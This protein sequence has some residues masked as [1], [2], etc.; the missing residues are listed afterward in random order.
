MGRL[1]MWTLQY[2]LCRQIVRSLGWHW[3]HILAVV[4]ILSC[5]MESWIAALYLGL[6]CAAATDSHPNM[7]GRDGIWRTLYFRHIVT[8][9]A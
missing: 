7:Y 9:Y 4:A 3:C 6:P 5:R 2:K 1:L 8:C